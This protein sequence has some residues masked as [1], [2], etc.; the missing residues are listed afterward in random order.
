MQGF[1]AGWGGEA[2]DAVSVEH[3]RTWWVLIFQCTTIYARSETLNSYA[4]I[5]THFSSNLKVV[6]N[7]GKRP[8]RWDKISLKRNKKNTG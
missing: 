2:V 1:E 5:F 8:F 6:S 4:L 7:G 3:S